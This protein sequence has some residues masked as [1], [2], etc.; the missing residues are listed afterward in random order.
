[1]TEPMLIVFGVLAGAI[2]LFAWGRPR[3]DIVAI[4]V[5]LALML[6]GVLTPQESLAGFGDPVVILI[7]AIF[8][9]GEALVNTG[10]AHRLGEAVLKAGGGNETRLI[11]LVMVLAGGIGAFMSSSAIVAMFI[12]VV[13]T[14]ANKTG[15][16]RKRMLMP[17]SVAALISGMM[18]L[19]ASSP[20]MIIEN[21]LR[22]HHL[23]PLGFF[24]WTPFGLAVLAASIAFMLAGRSLLSRQR[25]AEDAGTHALSTY[26]LIASYGLAEYWRRLR[27]PAGSPLIDQAMIQLLPLYERFG[28][29]PVGIEKHP[30]GK[31]RFL[32]ALPETVFEPDDALYVI[33]GQEQ[34]QPFI[35]TQRLIE[36]PR[37]DER[38]RHEALQDIGAVE[39]MLAPESKLI[40]KTLS[41]MEFRSRYQVTVLALRRRGEPLVT[42]L[43]NLALDFG[44]TLLIAGGWDDIQR[45]WEDRENFVV[46]TLPAE[47]HERLPARQRAPVAVGILVAMIAAMA[48]GLLPNSARHCSPRWPCS[49]AAASSWT[50]SIG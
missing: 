50:P 35:E 37:L 26:N 11:A 48:F 13:L 49:P 20:N 46:L 40:G 5:V 25:M 14:I 32:P 18:T 17:L 45:L 33:V 34:A 47:Y 39:I 9:V 12:P 4:L 23:A 10:V 16:N 29:V 24:S 36:L 30:Q 15:L 44:D 3:A 22:A 6:S 41:E 28:V 2:V 7:A 19:I 27:V 1:M 38:Q 42:D 8:I 43:A 21:T 31:A